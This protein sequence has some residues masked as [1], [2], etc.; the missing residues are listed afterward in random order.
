MEPIQNALIQ[1]FLPSGILLGTT[2]TDTEGNYTIT[3]LPG[4]SVIVIARAMGYQTETRNV[5][6]IR[7]DTIT[8]NF[9]LNDNP[10]SIRGFV[11]DRQTGQPISQALVQIFPVG[12]DVPI[13]PAF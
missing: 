3:G 5:E 4:G 13:P 7:G 1:V 10:A 2:L 12:S 11:T 8:V 9:L 6:V